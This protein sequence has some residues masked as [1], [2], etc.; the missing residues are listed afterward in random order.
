MHCI[1]LAE[2]AAL[3]RN[4]PIAAYEF[5]VGCPRVA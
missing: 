2:R 5:D 3:F 4:M 1:G